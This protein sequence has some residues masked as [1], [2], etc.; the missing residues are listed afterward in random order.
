MKCEITYEQRDG[1][2]YP[3]LAL[4]EEQQYTIGKYGLLHLDYI[5]KKRK[6]IYS[7]KMTDGTLNGY[8]HIIDQQAH[9][10]LDSIV[11]RMAKQKAVNEDMKA[12][13][14]MRW[15]QEMNAIKAAA[16]EIVLREV[17]YQ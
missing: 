12:R 7:S 6:P 16:E 1:I 17:V 2:C 14:P 15:V 13:N 11:S 8:L 9:E 5:K 3:C 4:P 10:L